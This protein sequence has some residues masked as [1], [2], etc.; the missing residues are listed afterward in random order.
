MLQESG[1][2]GGRGQA[3]KIL[4]GMILE[5]SADLSDACE[6]SKEQDLV[7]EGEAAILPTPEWS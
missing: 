4:R 7:L 6:E 1:G 5:P 3:S 2:C